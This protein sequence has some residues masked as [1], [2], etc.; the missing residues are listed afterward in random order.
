MRSGCPAN[1]HQHHS[2]AHSLGK[3]APAA[4]SVQRDALA[5]WWSTWGMDRPGL[6]LASSK[7]PGTG[8]GFISSRKWVTRSATRVRCNPQR[9]VSRPHATVPLNTLRLSHTITQSPHARCLDGAPV[10]RLCQ[11]AP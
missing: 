11:R 6:G 8:A 4:A 3:S 5:R 9:V 1:G 2:K 7:K 10:Q